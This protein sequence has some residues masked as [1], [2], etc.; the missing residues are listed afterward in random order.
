MKKQMIFLL[1]LMAF[2]LVFG[3][4]MGAE[5]PQKL[6]STADSEIFIKAGFAQDYSEAQGYVNE[7]VGGGDVLHQYYIQNG[8]GIEVLTSLQPS[9]LDVSVTN[10][11]LKFEDRRA[12]VFHVSY[13][14]WLTES[15]PENAGRCWMRYSDAV[16]AG[17][18][19]ESGVILYPGYKAYAFSPVDGEMKY[20]EIADLSDFSLLNQ[21]KIDVIR[22]DGISYFYI[23][24][25][26]AFQYEDNIANPV[27]FEGG[28]ELFEGSNRIR[29]DF[30]DF[31][32]LSQ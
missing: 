8:V 31:T 32:F 3:N 27:S 4:A 14:M 6:L 24:G 7:F 2:V 11:R 25:T 15:I 22:L 21:L 28:S 1:M 19:R 10:K 20:S 17:A 16:I 29:C 12:K 13:K 23:N 9:S 5:D 30:D 26:F 18:G